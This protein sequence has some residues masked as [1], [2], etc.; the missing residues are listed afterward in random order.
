M[1]AAFDWFSTEDFTDSEW[2]S[3]V[4][5]VPSGSC[6]VLMVSR[7]SASIEELEELAAVSLVDV[8]DVGGV[9]AVFAGEPAESDCLHSMSSL[10]VPAF[11]FSVDE[12]VVFA[13]VLRGAFCSR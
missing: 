7:S 4:V 5:V 11:V 1:S 12:A 13:G 10:T 3:T 8:G 6:V 2:D 9:P